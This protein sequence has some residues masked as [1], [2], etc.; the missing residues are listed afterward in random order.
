MAFSFTIFHGVE[1]ELTYE[2]QGETGGIEEEAITELD[3]VDI[4]G[5]VCIGHNEVQALQWR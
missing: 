3:A 4:P 2:C 5:I 1:I